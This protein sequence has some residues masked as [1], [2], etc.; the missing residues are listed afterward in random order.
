MSRVDS[1]GSI[2]FLE[3]IGFAAGLEMGVQP[4]GGFGDFGQGDNSGGSGAG[5]DAGHAPDAIF[6]LGLRESVHHFN[7]RHGTACGTGST[8]DAVVA[9]GIRC[10]DTRRR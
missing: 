1:G 4:L 3:N 5:P 6:R 9:V 2:R 8:L 7:A 10:A